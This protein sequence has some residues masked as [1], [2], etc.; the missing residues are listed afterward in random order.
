MLCR[1]LYVYQL[2]RILN[3]SESLTIFIL[4]ERSH[5][6]ANFSNYITEYLIEKYSDEKFVMSQPVFCMYIN[7]MH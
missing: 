4:R 2:V 1:Y 3:D 5:S 6:F 7:L